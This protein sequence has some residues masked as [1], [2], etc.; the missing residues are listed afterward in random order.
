[1]K[2]VHLK[3]L[4][5]IINLEHITEVRYFSAAGEEDEVGNITPPVYPHLVIYL[6]GH[7]RKGLPASGFDV[8]GEAA[9]RLWQHLIHEARAI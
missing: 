5:S 1:M 2:L 7:E 3:E 6:L 9:E 8:R 4:N